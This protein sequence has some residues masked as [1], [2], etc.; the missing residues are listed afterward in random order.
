MLGDLHTQC[1]V[2]RQF[3]VPSTVFALHA[4]NTWV[5]RVLTAMGLLGV[6]LLMPSSV[7]SCM[8]AHLPQ[9]Q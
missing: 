9:V 4:G 1:G 3:L 6:G 2:C 5:D 8:H 7:Y